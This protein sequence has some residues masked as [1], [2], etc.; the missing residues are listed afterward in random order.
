MLVDAPKVF[1]ASNANGIDSTTLE[2]TE[3]VIAYTIEAAP[4]VIDV[5]CETTAVDK[6]FGA[7]E[8]MKAFVCPK[9]CS[10]MEH[11][12]YNHKKDYWEQSSVCQAA[13]HAGIMTE[14]GG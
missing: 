11:K 9:N 12:V 4:T 14:F 6:L 2:T 1:Y 7:I 13:I 10:K 3:D 5:T 8:G